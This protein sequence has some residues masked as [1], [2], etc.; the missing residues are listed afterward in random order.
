M[1]N[2]LVKITLAGA[3]LAS[4]LSAA[5]A[6]TRHQMPLNAADSYGVAAWTNQSAWDGRWADNEQARRDIEN[7]GG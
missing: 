2:L 7:A 6:A 3:V 5:S 4:T 1:K